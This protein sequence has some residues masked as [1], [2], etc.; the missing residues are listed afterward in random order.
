MEIRRR[1]CNGDSCI[2][3]ES[4]GKRFRSVTDDRRKKQS[5][6]TLAWQSREFIGVADRIMGVSDAAAPL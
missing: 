3:L 2:P 6:S 5:Y 4:H 1:V